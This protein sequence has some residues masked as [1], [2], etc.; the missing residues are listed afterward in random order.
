MKKPVRMPTLAGSV[1]TRAG[2]AQELASLASG[3]AGIPA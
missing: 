2:A 3:S 1:T